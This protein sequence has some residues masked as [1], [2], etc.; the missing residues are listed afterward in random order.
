MLKTLRV[1]NFALVNA[2]DIE[3]A[4][5]FN[6]L[7]GETGAG[8]SILLEAIGFLLGGRSSASLVRTGAQGLSV[9]G[10][11]DAAAFPE[12]LRRRLELKTPSLVVRREL[13][14]QGRTRA[15]WNGRRLPV[16]ELAALGESLV[17][18]QSQNE[19][20]TL[21]KPA[22]QLELLDRYAGLEERRREIR[23]LYEECRR[24]EAERDGARLSAEERERRLELRRLELSAIESAR[25][26]PGEEREIEAAIP[27]LKH[28]EKAAGL[29]DAARAHLSEEEGSAASRLSAALKSVAELAR[30]DPG[31]E[32]LAAA[33][34]PAR[35]AAEEASR[36]LL[37][38]RDRLSM[39]P[40]KLDALYGRLDQIARAA[41]RYGGVEEALKRAGEIA[42]EIAAL[43]CGDTRQE[44]L[45]RRAAESRRR[46]ER[47]AE[48]THQ[49]RLQAA[50]KL[51]A[52]V[53]RE[54]QGLGLAESRFS[55]A[56]TMDPEHLGSTGS[57]SAEFMIAANPGEP[58]RPLR[59]TASGGELSRVALALK[60]ALSGAD[61]VPI[62]V[63]DEVDAGV[64][65]AVAR[66]VGR[67][68]LALSSGRQVL[69]VTHLPHIASMA[70]AH[71]SVRKVREGPRTA[72]TVERLDGEAR[73]KALAVMLGGEDR[74]EAGRRHAKELLT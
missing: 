7:T 37:G 27:L 45:D 1:K 13:D 69:C 22:L 32:A 19:H 36:T 18:F 40:G 11:F 29:I 50:R 31:F 72:V 52:E 10:V 12:E 51:E 42:E 26:R 67:K 54:L 34:E 73:V 71:F 14:G 55:V 23:G 74:S 3:F 70:E 60:T 49:K 41:K 28:A 39:D 61:G 35:A 4:P 46:L 15:E 9:E 53:L 47:V 2:V 48:E 17:D 66:A 24:L 58:E 33:L 5:G 63:F 16:S 21:L 43:E 65:G 38:H 68:L 30:I 64:G 59:Q 25:L 56:I 44:E 62:L 20:Q 8:K 6:V 57:D